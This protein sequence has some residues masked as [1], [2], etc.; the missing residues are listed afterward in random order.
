MT[1]LT[2]VNPQ[3]METLPEKGEVFVLVDFG[4]EENRQVVQRDIDTIRFSIQYEPKDYFHAW[5]RTAT[6]GEG[7]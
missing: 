7:E 2:L 5:S 6:F 4:H 1:T 3:P